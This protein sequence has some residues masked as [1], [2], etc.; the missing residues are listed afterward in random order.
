[1]ICFVGW[2]FNFYSCMM[3]DTNESAKDS[4]GTLAEIPGIILFYNFLK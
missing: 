1:M 4:L 3:K 2:I